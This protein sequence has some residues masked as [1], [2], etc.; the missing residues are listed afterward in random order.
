MFPKFFFLQN[1]L[2]KF[3][4]FQNIKSNE[5]EHLRN[6]DIIILR[7]LLIKKNYSLLD[8]RDLKNHLN[9]ME[10]SKQTTI[11][12][13]EERLK[14]IFK[15]ANKY[16]KKNVKYILLSK[17][18]DQ[19]KKKE[20]RKL[21]ISEEDYFYF[22]FFYKFCKK[23]KIDFFNLFRGKKYKGCTQK[24]KKT[25]L[26]KQ[27]FSAPINKEF[28]M[29]IKGND[30][31]FNHL[32]KYLLVDQNEFEY[33]NCAKSSFSA[34]IIQDFRKS[35]K[36]KINAKIRKWEQ[37]YTQSQSDYEFLIDMDNLLMQKSFKFPW[38]IVDVGLSLKLF[39][40][41]LSQDK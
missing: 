21:G 35:I 40:E 24:I 15:K 5:F 29:R 1:I 39:K 12:R 19:G 18:E 37:I 28:I 36:K 27:L 34:N 20:A 6:I 16:L 38:S 32:R 17:Y 13:L 3:F 4:L 33:I 9:L 22:F 26:S 8:E 25:E 31:Y 23:E 30:L 7:K 10:I 41:C 11:K 14:L 2:L